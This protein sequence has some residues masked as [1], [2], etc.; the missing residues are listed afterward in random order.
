MIYDKICEEGNVNWICGHDVSPLRSMRTPSYCSRS[1]P[2]CGRRSRRRR[3]ARAT[4]ARKRRRRPTKVPSRSVSWV[5]LCFENGPVP[6]RRGRVWTAPLCP[7][8]ARWRWRSSWGGR[9]RRRGWRGRRAAA[10]WAAAPGPNLWWA[11]TTA[12]RSR[13]RWD[14]RGRRL[15]HFTLYAPR[16]QRKIR[17]LRSHFF[18]RLMQSLY[19]I[20][21]N[22]TGEWKVSDV[23]QAIFVKYLCAS[24][25]T[26]T[27]LSW[28]HPWVLTCRTGAHLVP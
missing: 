2:A 23:Q 16:R 22:L 17:F 14:T 5:D 21:F 25:P 1:S 11:T 26:S 4:T 18:C 6:G 10:G 3:T 7:Q 19:R 27:P 28:S 20:A 15:L 24:R 12:K 8:P 13:R 9:R